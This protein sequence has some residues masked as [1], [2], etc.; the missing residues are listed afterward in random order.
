LIFYDLF[1]MAGGEKTGTVLLPISLVGRDG[2]QA[3]Y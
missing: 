2:N 3:Y 1:Y